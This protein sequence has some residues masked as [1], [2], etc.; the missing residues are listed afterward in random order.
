MHTKARGLVSSTLAKPTKYYLK[1]KG[2][3]LYYEC[4]WE[5]IPKKVNQE[6]PEECNSFW[7]KNVVTGE[8]LT[9][10]GN[11]VQVQPQNF[12]NEVNTLDNE[13]LINLSYSISKE[14]EEKPEMLKLERGEKIPIPQN[15]TRIV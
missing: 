2:C 10:D 5:L 3:G 7:V 13:G 14:G 4:F 12:E 11:R 6:G 8:F 9:Y 15:I 1:E